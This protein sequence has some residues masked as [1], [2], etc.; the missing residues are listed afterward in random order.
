[1]FELSV[2]VLIVA[3]LQGGLKVLFLSEVLLEFFLLSLKNL[4][5]SLRKFF[6]FSGNE[7]AFALTASVRF[8]DEKDGRVLI[9]LL[10]RH[11]S[12]GNL[13]VAFFVLSIAVFL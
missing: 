9:W 2:D 1:M 11:Y 7:D 6:E 3:I 5:N 4:V 8:Y 10:L 12:I 13:F